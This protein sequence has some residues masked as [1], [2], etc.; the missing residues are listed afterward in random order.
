MSN[1]SASLVKEL[2]E[3]TG[4]GYMECKKALESTNGDIQ[5]AILW[6]REHGMSRANQKSMRSTKEGMLTIKTN[7]SNTY[8]VIVEINCETDFVA[9]NS[10]FQAFVNNVAE[11]ALQHKVKSV[12]ELQ[13]LKNQSDSLVKEMLSNLIA[14]IGEN[15]QIGRIEY[16]EC[17]NG[18]IVGY[19]HHGGKIASLVAA[20][21]VHSTSQHDIIKQIAM[22]VAASSPRYLSP[23]TVNPQE[24]EQEKELITKQLREQQKPAA[25]IEKI[26]NGQIAKFYKDVCLLNQPFV[27]NP[28]ISVKE[29][30]QQQDPNLKIVAFKRVQLGTK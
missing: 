10:D 18:A 3:S 28:N 13:N 1:V 17:P 8:S 7:S 21:G 27:K 6:L 25:I 19:V 29:F 22:H 26:M 9:R 5:K 14:K 11:L 4:M 15:I 12:E 2:R 20:E 30:I 24:L 16:L 23:E